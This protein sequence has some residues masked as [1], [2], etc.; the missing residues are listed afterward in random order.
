MIQFLQQAS[1]QRTLSKLIWLSRRSFLLE[2]RPHSI[3]DFSN[4]CRSIIFPHPEWPIHVL[5]SSSVGSSF[6]FSSSAARLSFFS[7]GPMKD[8]AALFARPSLPHLVQPVSSVNSGKDEGFFHFLNYFI[9]SNLLC[10]VLFIVIKK[11]CSLYIYRY[12]CKQII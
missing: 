4:K 2:G 6:S 11:M 3:S 12:A 9:N 1:I 8:T 7:N 10:F 5:K